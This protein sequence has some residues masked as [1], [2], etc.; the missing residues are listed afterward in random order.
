MSETYKKILNWYSRESVQKALLEVGKNR[1]VVSV[2]KDGRF[3]RRPDIIQYSQDILQAVSEGVVAFHGSVERWAQPMKLDVG[4][5]KEELDS[6]RIGWDIFIDIDV[7]DFEIA[8]IVTKQIIEGLKDHGVVNYSCK[9]TGGKSFHIGICSES[10]PE[11]INMQ[12]FQTLYPHLL[13]KIIEYIKWYI[14][15]PLKEE[16]LMLDNPINIARRIKKPLNKIAG[17]EG[18]EPFKIVN[19]DV[20]GSRHLFRLPYSLHETTLLV[21]LPIKPERIDRFEK[22]DALPEKVKVEE[23]FLIQKVKLHDAEALIIEALDWALKQKVE[24]KEEIT[25]PK[26]TIKMREISENLFP[27]CVSLILKGLQDGRKRSVFVLINFLRNMGWDLEKMEKK[28]FE[29]N[30]K[31]YPPLRANYLRTQLRWHF[32]Q[33]RNLLPPNCDNDLFYKSIGVCNPDEICVGI[34]NP[35]NYPFKKL[36]KKK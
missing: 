24:L 3:G 23:K 33:S 35:I 5:V 9:F 22:E 30:E 29:W 14:K 32:R 20:F 19:I 11:K 8:K 4:M 25:K 16:M 28:I 13:Q 6:L 10:I 12:P 1:E 18:I 15:E 31:N 34:K 21:S 27:P 7:S 26:K 2:Y 36:K 17:E